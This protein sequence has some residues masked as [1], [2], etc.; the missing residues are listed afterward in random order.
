MEPLETTNTSRHLAEFHQI[1]VEM[2]G[3]SREDIT[4]VLEGSSGR[5]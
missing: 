5:S 1:D 3:A 4:G 2:A